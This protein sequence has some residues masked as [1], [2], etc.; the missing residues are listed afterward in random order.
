MAEP[1]A[2]ESATPLLADQLSPKLARAWFQE[3]RAQ[4]SEAGLAGAKAQR[5][6]VGTEEES[7]SPSPLVEFQRMRKSKTLSVALY[8][9]LALFAGYFLLLSRFG[10]GE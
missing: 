6:M 4:W 9:P 10:G 7:S 1:V 3:N 5:V 2:A 8:W